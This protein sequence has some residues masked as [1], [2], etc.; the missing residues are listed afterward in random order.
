MFAATDDWREYTYWYGY[1][2]YGN[3]EII[4][5]Y[6]FKEYANQ[7]HSAKGAADIFLLAGFI[8]SDILF[9]EHKEEKQLHRKS[10]S[11]AEVTRW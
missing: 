3:W 6:N 2:V 11:L 8:E 9:L 10:D 4:L 5:N 7:Q 1:G